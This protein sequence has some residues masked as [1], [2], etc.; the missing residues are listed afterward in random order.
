[1]RIGVI[2][3]IKP[4]ERRVGLTPGGARAL[5]DAGHAV[6]VETGAGVGS[7]FADE[8]YAGA[9]AAVEQEAG[10]V[11]AASEL[12]VKVKEPIASEYDNLHGGLTLFTYLHL[13]ADRPLTEA[14]LDSGATAIAYETVED[15]DGTLP[16]LT[17]MSEVAGRL[18]ALAGAH[19]LAHPAGG[20]GVLIS[21][22]PGVAPARV[23]V[24]GGG[25]VGSHAARIARGLEAEVTILERSLKRIRQLD[26][27]FGGSIC[28]LASDP[29]TIE[30]ELAAA[31]LVIGAVLI[32]G[33]AAPCVINRAQLAK[34]SP[35]AVLVD[36]AIDQGGCFETSRPTT[37]EDPTYVVD[38]ILHYC[39]ANIPGAVPVTAT[40]ALTN[41][42]LPFVLRLANGVDECVERDAGMFA[43]VNVRDG[44]VIHPG[45]AE[46]FPDLPAPVPSASQALTRS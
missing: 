18:G 16:L 6:S 32:P 27:N 2:K 40:R 44:C 19:H 21:G 26:L 12:V 13:A 45:V 28:V 1:M 43:G 36:I 39:V 10:T 11:W 22:V 33:A 25:V 3:E 14:L 37:H 4:A 29:E 42:T 38:G 23:L 17:P 5:V 8:D 7:G 31:D 34:L 46:T 15:E 30:R 9:G 24:I 35:G 41:A 20:P